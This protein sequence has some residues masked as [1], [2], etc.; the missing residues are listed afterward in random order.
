M[1]ISTFEH[2]IHY[3]SWEKGYLYSVVSSLMW[4]SSKHASVSVEAT[5][6]IWQPFFTKVLN[7]MKEQISDRIIMLWKKK[8]FGIKCKNHVLKSYIK[9]WF[10]CDRPISYSYSIIIKWNNW[11]YRM[12]PNKALF[13]RS[14]LFFL[15][16][17]QK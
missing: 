17:Y 14:F 10:K 9:I 2:K 8:F 7:T 6:N 12:H 4:N 1:W 13:L 5:H 16:C 3:H 11:R 15:F